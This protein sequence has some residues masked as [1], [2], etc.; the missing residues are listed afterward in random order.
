VKSQAN[1]RFWNLFRQLRPEVQDQ[2]REAYRIFAVNP[3]HPSLQFKRVG[4]SRPIYS[5]RISRDYRATRNNCRVACNAYADFQKRF[6]ATS[7]L[8]DSSRAFKP[9]VLAEMNRSPS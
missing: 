5:V 2:A 8:P 9:Q 4:H 3:R 1:A 7:S 6:P